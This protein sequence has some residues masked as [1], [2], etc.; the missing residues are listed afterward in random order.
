V[1]LVLD[2]TLDSEETLSAI[3]GF[4]VREIADLCIVEVVGAGAEPHRI[5][6]ACREPSR[7]WLCGLLLHGAGQPAHPHLQAVLEARRPLLLGPSETV[8]TLS[9]GAAEVRSLEAAQ[10]GGMVAV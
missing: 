2:N 5:K 3:A 9:Q 7:A 6:V 8:A 4:A 1:G 10:L